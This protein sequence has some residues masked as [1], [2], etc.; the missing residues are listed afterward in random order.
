VKRIPVAGPWI[1]ELEE[2]Y[3]GEALRD[4]WYEGAG[5]FHARFEAAFANY[6]GVRHAISLPS[7]TSAI[8]LS[9]VAAGVGP[10]DEVIVPES[11]WI[12]TAAPISY[13]GATPVF[14]DIDA[15]TW[16]LD[17]TSLER[18]ITGRTKAVIPVDLYGGMPDMDR[19]GEIAG[20][21]GLHVIEDAAEAVGSAYHDRPAGSFGTT[22]VFSFHGSKTLTTGEGGMLVTDSDALWERAL[23]LRDH[24][25]LPGDTLFK[26]TEVAF[27]Y[28]M[29][30]LQAALGLAQLERV[31]ELVARKRTIFGWYRDRLSNAPGI[32]LNVEPPGTRNSYWMVTAI[33]DPSLG[34]SKENLL[35]YLRDRGIDCRPFFYPLSSLDAYKEMPGIGE[36]R[37]DNENAYRLSSTGINLPS[38]LSLAEEDVER[39]ASAYLDALGLSPP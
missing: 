2:R 32:T 4:A 14:A 30:S 12:A 35:A 21:Y 16:C 29:S 11:T 3:V 22:G 19:I 10:G 24:G 28:K 31:D 39:V 5:L 36:A 9:L 20:R 6:L 8:H 1:T 18:W 17:P 34:R 7:A 23:V 33:A 13:V 26:N 15:V 38:A 25:R 37:H 27:K